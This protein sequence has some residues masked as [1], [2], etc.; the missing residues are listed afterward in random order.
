MRDFR[1]LKMFSK[2]FQPFFSFMCDKINVGSNPKT[3]SLMLV[4]PFTFRRDA[5]EN[6]TSLV[7]KVQSQL[8]NR[9]WCELR[10]G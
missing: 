4:L 6:Q 5:S 10:L 2:D 9:E 3:L 8:A 1:S 7:E